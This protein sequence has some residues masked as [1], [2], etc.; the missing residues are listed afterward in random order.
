MEGSES[1]ISLAQCVQWHRKQT[2]GQTR[3]SFL[4]CTFFSGNN[5]DPSDSWTLKP[6][7][8]AQGTQQQYLLLDL[9]GSIK[10]KVMCPIQ[11]W[12]P[13]SIKFHLTSLWTL[14]QTLYDPL[15]TVNLTEL[16]SSW[17]FCCNFSSGWDWLWEWAQPST[18]CT[19]TAASRSFREEESLEKGQENTRF[20]SCFGQKIIWGPKG[21]AVL[22]YLSWLLICYLNLSRFPPH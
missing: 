17:D 2:Q 3:T 13:S 10:L 5:C 19:G 11:W 7:S 20:S 15:G 1:S 8:P 6:P 12:Q 22:F 4:P 16:F 9:A 21:M 18:P 14:F